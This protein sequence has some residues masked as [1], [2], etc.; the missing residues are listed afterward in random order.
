MESQSDQ[1]PLIA[2]VGQTASGKSSLALA[3]AQRYNGE[4]ICADSRTVYKGMD[5]GT[6][7]PSPENRK[8]IPH[9]LLD[10]TTLDKSFTA[11]DFKWQ[12]QQAIRDIEGR[13]KLPFLVGGTGL[14]VDSV[15]FDFP[16]RGRPDPGERQALEQLSVESLQLKIEEMGLPLPA[17]ASNPRHLIR[18]IESAG[19][20]LECKELRANTLILGFDVS[21]E[22][23]SK[24]IEE[25]M[26][27]ML[28]AGLEQ[29][30]KYLVERYGWVQPLEAIGY[31][32]FREYFG[33]KQ[34]LQEVKQLIVRHTIQYAKRQK[35]W[36][37]RNPRIHWICKTE[38][39]VDLITTYLNK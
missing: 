5:I 18:Q 4:I 31:Q 2:I 13:G 24:R 9:H 1:S 3:L 32:E 25:R 6:A 33:G 39:A 8:R 22:V 11:A 23:L 14:Y 30:V 17:N 28:S 7:K 37:R 36:F 16:F 35:T 26:Q 21:K 19:R 20:P 12:A 38:E 29:E 15:L 10:V 34:E 27:A